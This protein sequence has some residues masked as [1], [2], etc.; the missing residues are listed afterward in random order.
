MPIQ[1]LDPHDAEKPMRIVTA[2]RRA[3]EMHGVTLEDFVGRS[4]GDFEPQAITRDAAQAKVA[5]LRA[6][7]HMEGEGVHRHIDGHEFP[8]E[9]TCALITIGGRELIVG[10]DHDIG[11]RKRLD[12]EVAE[13]RRLRAVGAMVGGVAHEFNNLLTPVLLHLERSHDPEARAVQKAVEQARELTQRI[14]TF[15]R[16]PEGIVEVCDAVAVVRECVGLMAKTIDRRLQIRVD[17]ADGHRARV[18]RNDLSQIVIN[19]ML[20]ARDT[21]VEKLEAAPPAGWRPEIRL[22]VSAATLE[23]NGAKGD[24][25][26]IRVSD[27]GM[28]IS[29]EVKERIFEPFFTTKPP[30]KGTGLGLATVWHLVLAAGGHVGIESEEGRGAAVD[31]YLP[32]GEAEPSA[33]RVAAAPVSSTPAEK[34]PAGRVLL[35]EDNDLVSMSVIQMLRAGGYEVTHLENGAEACEAVTGE[36]GR[37][38]RVLTDLNL[39]GMHGAELVGRIREAGYDGKVVVYS[40]MI[41]TEDADKVTRA[42]VAAVLQKPF[43]MKTLWEALR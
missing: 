42:G 10:C 36:L 1:L 19:L 26:L 31:I 6:C 23:R 25:V 13:G 3:A 7:S 39:P 35:V 27:N 38:D 29:A 21:L 8:I 34:Q 17:G 37:W 12:A 14:L 20:N 30:G 40:G 4:I 11:E 22:A 32:V 28:G 24:R 2:N 43:A 9:Y 33:T 5:S 15:G 41:G 18:A 16:K